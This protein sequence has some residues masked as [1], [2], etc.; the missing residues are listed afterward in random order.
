MIASPTDIN[1][2]DGTVQQ[3]ALTQRPSEK[4]LLTILSHNVRGAKESKEVDGTRSNTKF[5]YI[6]LYM[7]GND[8]DVYLV[9]ETWLEGDKDH[10]VINGIT[11]FTH[12]LENQNSSR[13]RGGM[14]I[15]MSRKAMKA[16][17]RAGKKDI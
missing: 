3:T 5:E 13:G 7:E 12:G 8:I 15:A 6:A 14:A 2:E 10:W 9:Q 16:W 4:Y 1:G 11:F 17:E